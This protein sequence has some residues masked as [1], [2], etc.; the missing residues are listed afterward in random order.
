MNW[1]IAL[2]LGLGLPVLAVG[3]FL[4]WTSPSAFLALHVLSRLL[5]DSGSTYTYREVASGLSIVKVYSMG[6]TVLMAVYL[7]H[8]RRLML[9]PYGV[10]ALVMICAALVGTILTARWAG[11]V[12]VALRWSYVWL[13]AVLTL[14]A[15]QQTSPQRVATILLLCL[16]YPLV[17]LAVAGALF[18]G[19]VTAGQLSYH[20]TFGHES[21]VG[22]MCLAII[23]L[24]TGLLASTRL[25]LTRVALAMMILVGHIAL[26]LSNYRTAL[27]SAMAY[28]MLMMLYLFPR[29]SATARV[30]VLLFGGLGLGLV[31]YKI[32]PEL[33]SRLSDLSTIVAD[34][35]S[36]FDFSAPTDYH[37]ETLLSGRVALIDTYMYYY[38]QAPIELKIAGLGPES[39]TDI[40]G[41]YAHNE[42]VAAL[43][44]QGV[45]GLTALLGVLLSG[46][47][48]VRK[49]ARRGD[50]LAKS[51]ASLLGAIVI[52]SLGTMPFRD[53]R[54]MLVLGIGLGLIEWYRRSRA[55]ETAAVEVLPE[56]S[57]RKSSAMGPTAQSPL[58]R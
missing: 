34:P 55:A 29:L 54:G 49:A 28:W 56:H 22:Y 8:R 51:M 43:V 17:N 10:M 32:G 4:M 27:V 45:V 24:A 58:A 40:V 20:G 41:K 46:F 2:A 23:A 11:F 25:P 9:L 5:M 33:A 7:W 47:V 18:G 50:W 3:L 35:G 38:L 15:A 36:H 21:H 14:Y 16:I 26:Y 30:N 12:N 1:T 42:Y 13:M 37:E 48:I 6:I 52:M 19:K 31:L 39:G 44:E 53:A 57:E